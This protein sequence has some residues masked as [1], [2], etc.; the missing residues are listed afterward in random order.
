MSDFVCLEVSSK[1]EAERLRSA[2][3]RDFYKASNVLS[4]GNKPKI[5]EKTIFFN[6]S[7]IIIVP[8][9]LPMSGHIGKLFK[10]GV[11]QGFISSAKKANIKAKK[12]NLGNNEEVEVVYNGIT[13]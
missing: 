11:L 2:I 4:G 8:F 10:R 13:D 6:K 9:Y 12:F 7:F 3:E 5:L 1:E